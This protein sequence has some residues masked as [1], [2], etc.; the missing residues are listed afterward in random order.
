[1]MSPI[2]HDPDDAVGSVLRHRSACSQYDAAGAILIADADFPPAAHD[3]LSLSADTSVHGF[4]PTDLPVS[5]RATTIA[6]N[7][8]NWHSLF[9]SL[10][11]TTPTYYLFCTSFLKLVRDRA[12]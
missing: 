2:L 4:D 3:G 8:G 7:T 9:L 12:S 5:V 10:I 11:E 6:V 1:M